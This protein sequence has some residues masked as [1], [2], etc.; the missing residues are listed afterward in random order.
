M[1]S[2]QIIQYQQNPELLTPEAAAAL[3]PLLADF[4]YCGTLH[5]LYLKALK[6][7]NNYLYPKQLK[8]T[9]IAVADRKKLYDWT[10]QKIA[11]PAPEKP[12]IDFKPAPTPVQSAPKPQA[13]AFI[14]EQKPEEIQ[15]VVV[16]EISAPKPAPL[17]QPQPATRKP[18]PL[19]KPVKEENLDLMNLPASVRETILRARKIREMYGQKQAE[20]QEETQEQTQIQEQVQKQIQVEEVLDLVHEDENQQEHTETIVVQ[21]VEVQ[22]P[23]SVDVLEEVLQ[24]EEENEFSEEETETEVT[25]TALE[26]VFE[27]EKATKFDGLEKEKV[28]LEGEA[29][30]A[31]TLKPIVNVGGKHSFLDWL[32]GG[33]DNANT[34]EEADLDEPQPEEMPEVATID[35]RIEDDVPMPASLPVVP[36]NEISETPKPLPV[37]DLSSTAMAEMMAEKFNKKQ[38]AKRIVFTPVP[39]N[40]EPG[41]LSTSESAAYITE[42][43]AQIYVNQKLFDRAI[44]AYEILRLK[45]PEKSSF[46]AARISE[47]KKLS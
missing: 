22:K 39:E 9:A 18:A 8:R 24:S 28:A 33:I 19:A 14:P 1:N 11:E 6:N 31:E 36:L 41:G 20:T 34:E 43:L 47:I 32:K 46:F 35:F 21:P 40:P 3:L 2:K 30:S 26:T 10:E 27:I 25:E 12:K 44:N 4:P 7:G 42:T 16:P 13:G 38:Q 45:Y 23:E 17:A 15:P 29:A 37:A 5:M